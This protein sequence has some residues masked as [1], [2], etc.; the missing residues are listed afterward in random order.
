[1]PLVENT[2]FGER[3]KVALA[4]ERLRTFAPPEG[5]WVADSGGKDSEV[6]VDL[7][8]RSEVRA[9]FH[10]SLTTIDHPATIHHIRRHHATTRIEHPDMPLLRRMIEVERVPPTRQARWCCAHYKERGG[11]GRFVVT[12]VRAAESSKRAG[13]SMVEHCLRGGNKRYLHPILDWSDGDV[14]DYIADRGLPVNPLYAQGY[15][16]IGCVLCPMSRD[17]ERDRLSCP[18]LYEA[19]HRAVVRC[20]EKRVADGRP[21]RQASGEEMWQWWI[22]RDAAAGDDNQVEL[23]T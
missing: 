8:R 1:M 18:R 4:I 14:W 12:G 23:F 11:D 3:D 10:H 21:V 2:L 9:D 22:A 16:R 5:Y 19:W 7:V 20:W 15:R 6:V 17:I 13:R